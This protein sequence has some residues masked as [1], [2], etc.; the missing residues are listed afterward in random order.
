V[1]NEQELLPSTSRPDLDEFLSALGGFLDKQTSPQ[2]PSYLRFL[3]MFCR[4]V[5][6]AEGHFLRTEGRILSSAVS[7]GLGRTFDEE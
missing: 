1:E 6:A 3:S 5:G 4:S 2:D 7:F